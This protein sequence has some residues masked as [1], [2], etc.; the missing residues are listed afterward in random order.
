M[1]VDGTRVYRSETCG[2][3]V[4]EG[5]GKCDICSH[6]SPMWGLVFSSLLALTCALMYAL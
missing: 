4:V 2:H 5:H 1:Y 6:K 3:Y